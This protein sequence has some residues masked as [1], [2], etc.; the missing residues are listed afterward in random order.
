MAE[1]VGR[2]PDRYQRESGA[3]RP[4]NRDIH[5]RHRPSPQ[6]VIGRMYKGV[7]MRAR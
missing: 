7:V 6:I 5:A 2:P 1:V 3:P 4:I